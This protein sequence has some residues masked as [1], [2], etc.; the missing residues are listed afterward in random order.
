MRSSGGS[1]G[2]N[3]LGQPPSSW[4]CSSG[5][6]SPQ[7]LHLGGS[8]AGR[9]SGGSGFMADPFHA[10]VFSRIFL[11][12]GFR[13]MHGAVVF[14]VIASPAEFPN[15]P[16]CTGFPNTVTEFDVVPAAI[17]IASERVDALPLMGH[18]ESPGCSPS[19]TVCPLI[20]LFLGSIDHFIHVPTVGAA[21]IVGCI[22]LDVGST[23]AA[24]ASITVVMIM[25]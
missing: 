14:P 25:A 3:W 10:V 15:L 24:G 22:F 17:F 16:Y 21:A 8:S 2:S 12:F 18:P 4:C 5:S 6:S 11:G 23:H 1:S 7:C 9:S 20:P 13:V 19:I